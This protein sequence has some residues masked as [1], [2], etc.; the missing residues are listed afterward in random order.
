MGTTTEP[1]QQSRMKQ[2]RGKGGID[3]LRGPTIPFLSQAGFFS[4]AKTRALVSL[5]A[6]VGL[7]VGEHHDVVYFFLGVWEPV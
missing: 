4:T 3:H 5:V 6:L 2:K 1:V 7:G